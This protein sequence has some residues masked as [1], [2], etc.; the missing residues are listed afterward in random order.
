M[1][2]V[3]RNQV[4][5]T[6]LVFMIAIAAYLDSQDKP[7]MNLGG[8]EGVAQVSQG[9]TDGSDMDQEEEDVF[10]DYIDQDELS[11]YET[12][13]I[14]A[15]FIRQEPIIATTASIEGDSIIEETSLAKERLDRAVK[16]AEILD[17][18]QEKLANPDNPETI[19]A[20]AAEKMICVEENI[21]IEDEIEAALNNNGYS[22]VYVTKKTESVEVKI[23]LEQLANE[24]IANIENI[25]VSI[26]EFVPSQIHIVNISS[27]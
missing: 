26:S 7:G 8:Q 27:K 12:Q 17:Q 11:S 3:K 21:R 20:D 5:I 4:V 14:S 24:E 19:R 2:S 10:A 25:A 16:R 13:Q 18:Y 23:G 15:N 6:M 22:D 9:E 1:F